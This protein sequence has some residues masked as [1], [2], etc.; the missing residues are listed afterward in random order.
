MIAV[1]RRATDRGRHVNIAVI[2]E[3]EIGPIPILA[4]CELLSIYMRALIIIT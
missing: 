3:V 4:T 1:V 2:A